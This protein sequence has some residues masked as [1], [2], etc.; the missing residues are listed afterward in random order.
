MAEV[1]YFLATKKFT[2]IS[3]YFINKLLQEEMAGNGMPQIE[4][5]NDANKQK[6]S[7]KKGA[8]TELRLLR[9]YSKNRRFIRNPPD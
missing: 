2:Y 8:V 5:S 3:F 1:N 4:D 9:A 7:S 6:E